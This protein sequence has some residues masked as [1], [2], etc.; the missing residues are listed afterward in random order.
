[1]KNVFLTSAPDLSLENIEASIPIPSNE[2]ELQDRYGC[3]M[4][5]VW[6][7]FTKAQAI[8]VQNRI[9]AAWRNNPPQSDEDAAEVAQSVADDYKVVQ[10]ISKEEKAR[11]AGL[12]DAQIE[13][14]KNLNIL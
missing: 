12:S 3:S 13:L 1:M 4:D 10:R 7:E 8:K 9:R 6:E 5:Y 11:D 14:L 2:K